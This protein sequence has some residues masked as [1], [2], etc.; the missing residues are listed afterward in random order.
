MLQA[1]HH[2]ISIFCT[3]ILLLVLLLHQYCCLVL[4]V[5]VLI[6]IVSVYIQLLVVHH[7]CL[8]WLILILRM[9]LLAANI[10]LDRILRSL[11]ITFHRS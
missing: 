3:L 5:G 6:M 4:W 1:C 7:K 9:H 11:C 8:V 10:L 2:Y